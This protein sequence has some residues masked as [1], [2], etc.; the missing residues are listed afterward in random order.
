[1]HHPAHT[2]TGPADLALPLALVTERAPHGTDRAPEL[3]T[4]TAT[5]AA[6]T[7]T[8]TT[9]GRRRRAARRR[10]TAVRG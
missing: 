2:P 3:R 8:A 9:T 7:T 5:T 6:T 1:M 10:A 4:A